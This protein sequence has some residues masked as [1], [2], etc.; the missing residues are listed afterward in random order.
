MKDLIF[1]KVKTYKIHAGHDV[2]QVS[3]RRYSMNSKGFLVVRD[4]FFKVGTFL[5]TKYI[6]EI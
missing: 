1:G 6:V 2:F 3:G 5:D 4:C